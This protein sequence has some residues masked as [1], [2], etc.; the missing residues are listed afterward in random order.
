METCF[1]SVE[2]ANL[3]KEEISLLSFP[4][5]MQYRINVWKKARNFFSSGAEKGSSYS[6]CA[7]SM[8]KKITNVFNI[9]KNYDLNKRRI[10]N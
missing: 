1:T 8:K 5:I 9:I 2:S 10:L 6:Q 7:N 4:D 3:Q